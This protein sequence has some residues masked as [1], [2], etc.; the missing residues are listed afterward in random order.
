[1]LPS[2]V[3]AL[4]KEIRLLGGAYPH[5]GNCVRSVYFGGGTPSVLSTAQIGKCLEAVKNAFGLL[6]LAEITIETNPGSISSGYFKDIHQVGVN[7]LSIGAQSF[8]DRFL[9]LL[10]RIHTVQD[11]YNAVKNAR[12][13]G[14]E[15]I[16]LDLIFGVPQQTI[17]N[18]Q[19]DLQQA[20]NLHPE[21]ISLYSLTV[22]PG[23]PLESKISS[24]VLE[25]P[26]PDLNADMYEY[27]MQFL[28][29]EGYD[30]YEISNWA[31]SNENEALH[32]KVYWK[33]E[34]YLG[35]GVA[36]HGCTSGFRTANTPQIERY[37][38]MMNLDG[39][40][41][42]FPFSPANVDRMCI[43]EKTAM[44]ETMMLGLRLIREGVSGASFQNRF[45][46]SMDSIFASEISRL[47]I[48]G[49]VM[50]KEFQ[51]GPHLCLTHKG[52]MLGNQVFVEFV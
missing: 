44:Q 13:A 45:A 43:D 23:T 38:E 48:R 4:R 21:H 15:N 30:H 25:K 12:S 8:S 42:P 47:L 27:A 14:I 19:M 22:E 35:V 10:G 26:D 6:D 46:K 52:I 2:Y 18:W 32:N 49:L 5:A 29:G 28:K 51:D 20:A 33:N 16:N 24:G 9:R 36:A 37:L 11:T 31:I 40:A 39:S 41:L 34:P 17:E 7:R 50:W 1:M 3:D